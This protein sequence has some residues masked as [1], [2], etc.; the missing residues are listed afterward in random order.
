[1]EGR[2][3][4]GVVV[5]GKGGCFSEIERRMERLTA[6]LREKGPCLFN[7]LHSV[8]VLALPLVPTKG[9]SQCECELPRLGTP[10]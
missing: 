7:W 2:G 8:V 1:M 4:G 6:C 10:N 9:I 3:G 5:L